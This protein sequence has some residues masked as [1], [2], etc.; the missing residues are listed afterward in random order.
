MS[1]LQ[2]ISVYA[3]FFGAHFSPE[4][5]HKVN[6]ETLQEHFA[7][8]SL[9]FDK[10]AKIAEAQETSGNFDF[11]QEVYERDA[12][13]L[14]SFD[15]SLEKLVQHHH[16]NFRHER[17][18]EHSALSLFPHD[19]QIDLLREIGG[20]GATVDTPPGFLPDGASQEPLRASH[21]NLMPTM[22]KH[23]FRLWDKAKAIILPL[24]AITPSERQRLHKNPA[25]WAVK[26]DGK[27]GRFVTDCSNSN[28]GSP[29]LNDAEDVAKNLA[30]SRY[31]N[32][33]YPTITS[34]TTN[35]YKFAAKRKVSINTC[36][37]W[38]DDIDGAFPQYMYNPASA[39]LLCMFITANL[40]MIMIRGCFGWTGSPMVWAVL[41]R[42]LV[43]T[44]N[45]LVDGEIDM[46]C[47]DAM[48]ISLPCTAINDQ[49]IFHGLVRDTFNR[50]DAIKL[51][52]SFP[53]C[54]AIN[55]L[56]GWTDLISE[57]IRPND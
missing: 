33:V 30:D 42:A 32:I 16:S 8:I 15:G 36:L 35:W 34:L 29:V 5:V 7:S 10:E 37:L 56:G 3:P 12:T 55:I 38:K 22:K 40:L 25:D 18:N 46:F 17:F 21:L 39:L 11:P 9:M 13:L 51:S 4:T 23:A 6:I 57:S 2:Q 28:D 50:F 53:P 43:R 26:P 19:P 48:G 44:E 47:D 54:S 20:I 27:E 24:S 14:S 1:S 45:Q 31:G 41:M 49:L 52:K